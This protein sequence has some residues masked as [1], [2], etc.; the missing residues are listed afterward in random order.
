MI[1]GL[2]FGTSNSTVGVMHEGQ[3]KMVPLEFDPRTGQTETT[4]P[5]ALFFD[6]ETDDIHFGRQAIE[7][8]TQGDFGRLMRSMKSVLG[9]NQMDEGTQIK[10]RVYSYQDIIG[11]FVNSLKQRAETFIES[12]LTHVVMGRPVHFRDNNPELDQAAEARLGAIARQVGFEEVSF[13]YEPI[14]AAYDYEQQVRGEELAMIIDIGGGTSDFTIIRLSHAR[15][16]L[17]DRSDDI[18]ANHGVHIGGTDFD[19]NISLATVMPYLG[20]NVHYKDIPQLSMPK[21]Y[22]VDLATWHRIHW[23]YEPKILRDINELRLR[24]QE[25]EPIERLITL[26]KNKAGHRLA[27]EVEQA[28]IQ[29]SGAKEAQ[30]DLGFIQKGN[31]SLQHTATQASMNEAISADVNR[32]FQTVDETLLQSGLEKG[33]IQTIFTTGGSTALPAIKALVHAAFP[34]AK[35]VRGDLYNSVGKGLLLEAK[36]RYL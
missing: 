8:Y 15:S 7:H 35:W 17:P 13:Q 20:M 18:L 28:K 30:L 32:V 3:A 21:H 12:P 9:S 34:G 14:A 2:D 31:E 5:S 22:F 36:R 33:D 1:C 4:L 24:M 19:R 27:A 23:L 16:D 11:F 29:L 6:F 25:R 26:L 10:S